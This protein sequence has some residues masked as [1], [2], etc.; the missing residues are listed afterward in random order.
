MKINRICVFLLSLFILA[1]AAQAQVTSL[2]LNSDPGDFIG[3]GEN[4]FF[5]PADGPFNAQASGTTFVNASFFGPG[6]AFWFLNFGAPQGQSLALGTYTG[7]TNSAITNGPTM[8]IVGNGRGCDTITGQFT[9]LE[10]TYNADGSLASLDVAFEQHCEGVTPALRGEFRFNAH[11]V[12]SLTGPSHLTVSQNQNVNFTVS[13]TDALSTHVSLSA[14]GVPAGATFIDNGDNTGTF[15]WTPSGNQAGSFF[16]TFQG[17]DA[18]GNSGVFTTAITVIVP[19]PPNDD[20]NTPTVVQAIPFT[21]IQDVTNATVAPDDPFCVLS[22]QTVWFSFTPT[23]DLRLEANTFGSNY[24]TTLAVYTG[25]RGSLTSLGCNDDSNGTLQ[26]RVRF[27]AKAGTTYYI[28]V[29]S[30]SLTFGANLVFNLIQAPAPLKIAPSVTQFGSVDPTTGAAT[31]AGFVSCTQPAFVTLSGQLK[32]THGGVPITGFFSTFVACDGKTPWSASIQTTTALFH[33]R[34]A[35]LFT[36]GKADI[37]GTASAF[38]FENGV[39]I[40]Q[41]FAVTI[42]LRGKHN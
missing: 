15:N 29:S 10:L 26:S 24:D 14:T 16:V 38:D 40:Q 36:G 3:G 34:S 27:D 35:A 4:V 1:A 30:F 12:V 18:A 25:V 31:I 39:F 8:D 7:V 21:A 11:P 37:S 5:T 6:N 17:N 9:V 33:G 20:F 23:Q 19:P 42:T 13:A 2:S 28:Q 32:Q 41:N 22:N